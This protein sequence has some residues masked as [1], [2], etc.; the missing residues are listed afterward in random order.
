MRTISAEGDARF[1]A[2]AK[3]IAEWQPDVIAL[4]E[5]LRADQLQSAT[6]GGPILPP[7]YAG[8][9]GESS[10]SHERFLLGAPG[11]STQRKDM[12]LPET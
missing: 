4:S 2:I 5:V 1:Q 6:G 10:D 9:C 3:L 11:Q 7:G 12:R 8:V